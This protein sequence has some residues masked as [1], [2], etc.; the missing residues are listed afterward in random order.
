[1]GVTIPG[2][3]GEVLELFEIT[4]SL[5]FNDD[6]SAYL[7]RTPSSAGNQKTFTWSGWVKR[8]ALNGVRQTIFGC[9]VSGADYSI[10]E[11]DANDSLKYYET[12]APGGTSL[13]TTAV[14][15]DPSA[16]YH[17]VLAVDTDAGNSADRQKLYV[18]GV[19]VTDFSTDTQP[20]LNQKS[21]WGKTNDGAGTVT[22]GIGAQ[23]NYYSGFVQGY[24]GY[25]AEWH[26]V[27]GQALS[28]TDFGEF[29]SDTGIW[30]PIDISSLS[31]PDGSGFFLDFSDSSDLG[32]D[33]SSNNNDFTLNNISAADQALDVP[34]NNF[35]CSFTHDLFNLFYVINHCS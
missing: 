31:I 11:F 6:D 28:P 12:G 25:M 2:P 24:C 17:I 1:M 19:E 8:G 5:R 10:L 15:R 21:V 20:G 18:N 33:S 26:W 30:K 4:N 14:Y 7:T 16:W 34:T 9:T 13:V 22:M 29:D 35:K 23:Y 27:E 3:S 32:N